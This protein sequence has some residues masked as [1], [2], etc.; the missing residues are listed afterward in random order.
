[1]T[2]SKKEHG[3]KQTEFNLKALVVKKTAFYSFADQHFAPRPAV[4]FGMS[5]VWELFQSIRQKLRINTVEAA[6]GL[7][8]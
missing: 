3:D 1:M 4:S 7:G 5:S 6:K 8:Q 2:C